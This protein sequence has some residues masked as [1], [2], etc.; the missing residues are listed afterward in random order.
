MQQAA[1]ERT[2]LTSQ[3]QIAPKIH[4]NA[5]HS[6]LQF[7]WVELAVF[8]ES[9]K[10]GRQSTSGAFAQHRVHLQGLRVVQFSCVALWDWLL[11]GHM[12]QSMNK[13]VSHLTK[14]ISICEGCDKSLS[15]VKLCT[16]HAFPSHYHSH[17]F[18]IPDQV[19]WCQ[20]I[21]IN[22]YSNIEATYW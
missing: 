9:L 2:H 11:E 21:H 3:A 4:R 8:K 16:L 6:E 17:I 15:C 12:E 14:C 13:T 10:A 19:Q 5:M 22:S 7:W 18:I 1:Q 20:F